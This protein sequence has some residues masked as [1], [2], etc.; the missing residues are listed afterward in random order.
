MGLNIAQTSYTA[1]ASLSFDVWTM[2][3]RKGVMQFR[4]ITRRRRT[5]VAS[6]WTDGIVSSAAAQCPI[7]AMDANITLFHA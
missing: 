5:H 1:I 4:L 3:G 2:R 6:T 7:T